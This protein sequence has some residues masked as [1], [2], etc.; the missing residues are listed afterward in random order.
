[1]EPRNML[2]AATDHGCVVFE[3]AQNSWQ[4][5]WRGLSDRRVTS[6]VAREGVVLAGT[7][8]GI[9]RS[10]DGGRAWFEADAGLSLRHVRWLA[11]HP[12]ISDLEFA[13]TEPAGIF[14]SHDGAGSWRG[15]AEVEALRDSHRWFLPYSP[16]AGCVRSFAFHGRRAY[17][18]VEVGGVL[19]SDDAGE[20]WRLAGGSTG[21]PRF[22][23]P[24]PP[25][26]HADVHSVAAH[27]TSP[28]VVFAATAEGL[29]RSQDGG[30][31]WQVTHAGSYCRAAWIDPADADHIVL[32]PADSV[33]RMNGR[34][35]VTRDGGQN[36]QPASDG[37]DPPWP[38]SMVE[39]FALV[40]EELLAITNDGRV[41]AAA[42]PTL[43][44]ERILSGAERVNAVAEL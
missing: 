25:L 39:R 31:T 8:D 17:A 16:Q 14:M 6:I 42:V 36:W 27:P 10:D 1:M 2:C 34:I 30:D 11:Y 21:E 38:G 28:D 20:T 37:L 9:V 43:H 40:G 41:Y 12:D 13:G 44:W 3:H 7:T 29:Y 35:E 18:A 26:V 15:C 33:S 32:G 4:E 19:R 22:D 24:A 23:I 5:K